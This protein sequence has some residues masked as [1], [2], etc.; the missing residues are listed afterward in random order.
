MKRLFIYL[1]IATFIYSCA[2]IKSYPISNNAISSSGFYYALPKT[3]LNVA[4]TLEREVTTKGVYIDYAECVGIPK[5]YTEKIKKETK[6]SVE[7]ATITNNVYLDKSQIFKLDVNQKFLNKSDFSIEYAT[8]GEL[9]SATITNENQIIPAIITTANIVK[10]IA[11]SVSLLGIKNTD[12]KNG[13]CDKLPN[14]IKD[15]LNRLTQVQTAINTLLEKGPDGLEQAQLEFRLKE[16]KAIRDGIISKFTK[17]VTTKKVVV[18]FEIDPSQLTVGTPISLILFKE[19]IGFKRLY[20]TNPHNQINKITDKLPFHSG[21]LEI[22]NKKVVL[23]M[24]YLD[25]L[26]NNGITSSTQNTNE[27]NG[28]FYY[29]IPAQGKFKVMVE[30]KNI[31]EA[32]LAIPQEGI[33]VPAPSNLRNITFKLHPGLGSIY[34]VSGKSSDANYGAI[35]SLRKTIL[36]DKNDKIIKDLETKIKIKELKEKLESNTNSSVEEN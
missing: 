13:L 15:D 35:D 19:D 1:T 27:S 28:S 32:T 3:Y 7:S 10:D 21:S 24:V 12:L 33:T 22:T 20:D 2:Q 30:G 31:G 25:K 6:Y 11:G 18:N 23:E 34:S 4:V 26:V 9:T 17:T 29:R 36:T 16:L 5:S 14:F 8:N